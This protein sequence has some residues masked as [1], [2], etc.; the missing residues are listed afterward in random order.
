MSEP[1][2]PVTVS[3]TKCTKEGCS[4]AF[5]YDPVRDAEALEAEMN[6]LKPGFWTLSEDSKTINCSF[7]CRNFMAAIAFF[8][9]AAAVAENPEMNHHPDLHLTNYKNVRVRI[10]THS[11]GGLTTHDFKLARALD[12]IEVD[13]SPAWLKGRNVRG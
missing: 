5:V 10:Y 11:A 13:Y 4:E 3:D 1:V 12:Q 7:T 2:T 8:N 9:A 6:T